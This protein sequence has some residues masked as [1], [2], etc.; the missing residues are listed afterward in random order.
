MISWLLSEALIVSSIPTEA[1]DFLQDE[2]R[3]VYI[4]VDQ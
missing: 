4:S 3:D 2:K 1:N